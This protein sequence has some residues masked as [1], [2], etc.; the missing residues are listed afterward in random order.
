MRQRMAPGH[1]AGGG[2]ATHPLK[3]G[4]E[5]DSAAVVTLGGLYTAHRRGGGPVVGAARRELPG[6]GQYAPS[7]G[8]AAGAY[9]I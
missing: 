8:E 4:A 5:E 3:P 9:S 2:R 7:G 1:S 6:A